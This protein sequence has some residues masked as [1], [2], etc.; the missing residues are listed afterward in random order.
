MYIKNPKENH[1]NSE[2]I[3]SNL[4]DLSGLDRVSV[5]LLLAD[6]LADGLLSTPTT[7]L[8]PN[9]RS[10]AKRLIFRKLHSV[11]HTLEKLNFLRFK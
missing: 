6:T 3:I 8:E 11:L 2:A 5:L 4:Q 10:Q 7:L 1:L 9:F